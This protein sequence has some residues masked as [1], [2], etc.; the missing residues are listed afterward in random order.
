MHRGGNWLCQVKALSKRHH[1]Q[2]VAEPPAPL[3]T[4]PNIV[5]TV[6]IVNLEGESAPKRF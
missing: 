1:S 4:T 5:V 2:Y 6:K 3:T